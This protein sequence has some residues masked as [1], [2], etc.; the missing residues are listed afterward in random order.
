MSQKINKK[1]KKNHACPIKHCF[2]A[3]FIF[4]VWL[5]LFLLATDRKIATPFKTFVIKNL[6]LSS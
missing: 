2:F 6:C 5:V 4:F 1:E 3:W